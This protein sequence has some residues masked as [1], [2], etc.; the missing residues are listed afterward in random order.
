MDLIES[1]PF[2][3]S[4]ENFY[5]TSNILDSGDAEEPVHFLSSIPQ[6][7]PTLDLASTTIH[8]PAPSTTHPHAAEFKHKY[9]CV[10][11]LLK[12]FQRLLIVLRMKTEILIFRT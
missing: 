2:I 8:T 12:A 5:V 10:T 6:S 4:T 3:H 11:P 9:D 1:T 7:R